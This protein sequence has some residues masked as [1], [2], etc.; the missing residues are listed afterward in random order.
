MQLLKPIRELSGLSP[1]SLSVVAS[2]VRL[3]LRPL[4]STGV[5]RLRQYY[6]PLRHPSQPGLSLTS[7]PLIHTEITAGTS[8]F[9]PD[10]L[11]VHAI[12]NTP[13]SF[14]YFVPSYRSPTFCP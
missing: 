4:P 11:F 8:R 12:P 3:Q 2:C 5:T 1:L 9:A 7:C 13:P 14:F 6:E 10:P